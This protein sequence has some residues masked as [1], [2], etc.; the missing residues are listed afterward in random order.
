ML[1]VDARAELDRNRDAHRAAHRRHYP[2]RKHRM[3]HERAAVARREYLSHRAAHIYVYDIGRIVITQPCR[4]IR[5]YRRVAAEY[6]QRGGM[7]IL[8]ETRELGRF[9]VAVS[10]RLCRYHLRHDIIRAL[11]TTQHTEGAVGHAR[12]RCKSEPEADIYISYPQG[13]PPN[14][15]RLRTSRAEKRARTYA[16][17]I[18]HFADFCKYTRQKMHFAR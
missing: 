5:H 11:P 13:L 16:M 4:S 1:A 2:A 10:Y 8:A 17:I 18:H 6:L 7:L 14:Q 3:T 9:S 12:H 15:L